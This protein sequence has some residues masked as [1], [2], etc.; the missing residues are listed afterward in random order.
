MS[1]KKRATDPHLEQGRLLAEHLF[2]F[3]L[4]DLEAISAERS[5][6]LLREYPLLTPAEFEDVRG[7][8]IEAKTYQQ[9]RIGWQAIPHD[10]AVLV[11]VA[12]T[13]LWDIRVGVVGGIATLVL[14]ESL[15]QVYFSRRLYRP[16][17]LIV[18][19]T[20]PAYLCLGYLLYRRGFPLSWAIGIAVLVWAGTYLLGYL[21]RIPM[22]LFLEAR[23]KGGSPR[24][25]PGDQGRGRSTG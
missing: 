25:G 4:R 17:S 22:R 15:S 11:I 13:A 16:L 19:L 10:L 21:A 5:P 12:L 14:L 8:V 1:T 7:Q 9:E 23:V 20:Y 18:W 6:D 2:D 3:K 24:V